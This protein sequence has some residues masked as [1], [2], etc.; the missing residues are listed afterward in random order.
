MKYK[1]YEYK[2]VDLTYIKIANNRLILEQKLEGSQEKVFSFLE[3]SGY[4]EWANIKNMEWSNRPYNSNTTRTAILSSGVVEEQF[5]LWE[6][7]KRYVFRIEKSPIKILDILIEDWEVK[8][9]S[10]YESLLIWTLY[11]E[12]R[13]WLKYLAP[14]LN[15]AVRKQSKKVFYAIPNVF[16]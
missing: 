4:W 16:K 7:N 1:T 12:F 10:E 8:Y 6:Q 15:I 2:K 13:G 9:I 5:L 3:Q 14:L 11:Y